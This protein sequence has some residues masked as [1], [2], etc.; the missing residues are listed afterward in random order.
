VTDARSVARRVVD[1]MLAH[2]AFSRWLGLE[3]TELAPGA[4]A[5]TMTVRPD[6]VNGFGV[7]HGGIVFGLADSALAFASNSHGRLAMSIENSVR[8]PA[9]V[10]PGDVLTARASERHTT[11]RLGFYTVTVT[12]QEGVEVGLFTGTVYRTEKAHAIPNEG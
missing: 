7:A 11:N 9:P 10:R 4:C 6:M 5:C 8:Y 12:N 1:G 3:V 2:D